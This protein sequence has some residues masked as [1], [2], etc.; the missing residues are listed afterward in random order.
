MDTIKQYHEL[1]II[2]AAI[3][4]NGDFKHPI[5]YLNVAQDVRFQTMFNEFAK[6]MSLI[7]ISR[8]G[9]DADDE[10]PRVIVI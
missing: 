7:P 5:N 3:E 1:A 9:G 6:G 2:S 4:N 8:I 10:S